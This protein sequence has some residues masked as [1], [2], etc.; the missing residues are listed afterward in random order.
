MLPPMNARTW[1]GIGVGTLIVGIGL[2]FSILALS[3]STVTGLGIGAV[4]LVMASYAMAMFSGADDA[5][6]VGFKAALFGLIT[7]VGMFGMFLGTGNDLF[8][9]AAPIAAVGLS[10][11]YA[12]MPVHPFLR[13]AIRLASLAI[14]SA[15]VWLVFTVD[16]TVYGLIVPLIPLPAIGLADRVYDRIVDVVA[17]D[18]LGESDEAAL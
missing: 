18:P 12:L 17:E 1:P 5:P 8:V 16:P 13:R 11:T 15:I 14:G 2:W 4:A 3:T 10:G 6:S 7:G 9:V